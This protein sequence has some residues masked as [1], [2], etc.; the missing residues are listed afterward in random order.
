MSLHLWWGLCWGLPPDSA[1]RLC[2]DG[3]RG[4]V[5]ESSRHQR[6]D[7][8][9]SV[10]AA[11][12]LDLCAGTTGQLAVSAWWE[13]REEAALADMLHLDRRSLQGVSVTKATSRSL[14][15]SATKFESLS[16]VSPDGVYYPMDPVNLWRK[17]LRRLLSGTGVGV[18]WP[19]LLPCSWV[20]VLGG[21]VC[22]QGHPERLLT[23]ASSVGAGRAVHPRGGA[24]QLPRADRLAGPQFGP[25]LAR[26]LDACCGFW[27]ACV[28]QPAGEPS[29]RRRKRTLVHSA[30][31]ASQEE[32]TVLASP[33]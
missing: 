15:L 25:P 23:D 10:R 27:C 2:W 31:P 24:C 13:A 29:L 5:P 32:G 1:I 20:V 11:E 33:E 7:R 8:G 19:W 3:L 16:R 12:E 14:Q 26:F 21:S 6:G 9:G 30:A 18:A 17:W 22:Q 4:Q 28:T